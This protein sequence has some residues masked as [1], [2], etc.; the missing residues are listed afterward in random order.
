MF[1][2]LTQ[3]EILSLNGNNLTMLPNELFYKMADL[4]ILRLVDNQFFCDCNLA[5]LGRWLK[6]CSTC[7][8]ALRCLIT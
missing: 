8:F 3:V 5:W 2:D 4:R 7:L 1:D 6:V